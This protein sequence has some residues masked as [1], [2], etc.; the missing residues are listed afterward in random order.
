MLTIYRRHKRACG[1]RSEPETRIQV[2]DDLIFR[3]GEKTCSCPLWVDGLLGERNVRKSLKTR[4]WVRAKAVVGEWNDAGKLPAQ[5]TERMPD[6][7]ISIERAKEEFLATTRA[8][9]LKD[10]TID[11]Y[12]ILFRQLEVF[13]ASESIKYLNQLDTPMLNRFRASWKGNSG[14]ADLK[15]LER[16]RSF[17]KF[18]QANGYTEQNPAAT[19]RN[20]KIRPNP[21]LPFSQEEMLAILAA[22]AKKIAEVRTEGKNR[23]RR[24]R[25]LVLFLRYTGLRI[26]DAIGCATDR[27]QDGK[28]ELYTAKTGQHVY[29]PLPAFVVSELEAVPKVSDRYWF[30]TGAGKLDTARKKWSEALSVLFEAAKVQEGHAHRFR[31][32]FAVELLKA[33]TPIERVSIFLGHATVGITE[34]HYNPWNRARQE[35]A[36]ADVTRSW[37]GDPIAVLE[38]KGTNRV[39]GKGAQIN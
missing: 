28:L 33:G 2:E 10:S 30:W 9:K 39:R 25:A 11:R 3:R 16:L 31:D 32:T 36:E 7:R 6:E 21:T 5:A 15:K 18:A 14:L 23:A 22:A 29:C 27:L 17:F 35:Q 34:K 13:A 26:S 20:P 38:A 37:K 24:V 19:I 12:R 1:H 8:Q 4:N